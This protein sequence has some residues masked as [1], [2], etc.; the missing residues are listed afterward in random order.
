[1]TAEQFKQLLLDTNDMER[2]VREHLFKGDPIAFADAPG[3]YD[4]L[5]AHLVRELREGLSEDHIRV[6][7]SAKLGFS[8]S[9]DRFPRP[10]GP[11]SDI[12]VVVVSSRLFD[13]AW[14]SI[15]HWYYPRRLQRLEQRD[16]DWFV[17]R[18]KDLFWGWFV[19]DQIGYEGLTLPG[20]LK[21][22]RDLSTKWFSAFRS[23]S[24]HP[25][26]ADRSISGRLYRNWNHATLYHAYGLREIKLRLQAEDQP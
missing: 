18:E 22:L 9:P 6:V 12:D 23:L 20:T 21:P 8:L 25:E 16:W 11:T 26:L 14:E 10:F 19:P 17:K 3:A 7:G 24:R 4:T 15:L 2:V 1:M 13:I 5:R